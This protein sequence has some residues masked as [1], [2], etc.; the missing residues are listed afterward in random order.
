MAIHFLHARWARLLALFVSH[1]A[2]AHSYNLTA[3][4]CWIVN[5]KGFSMRKQTVNLWNGAE[6][7]AWATSKKQ[8]T[9]WSC[10]FVKM[11]INWSNGVAQ[12]QTISGICIEFSF[13]KFWFVL[14]FRLFLLG[15]RIWRRQFPSSECFRILCM[16]ERSPGPWGVKITLWTVKQNRT[17]PQTRTFTAT[18]PHLFWD[19]AVFVRFKPSTKA[20][21]AYN[22]L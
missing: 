8:N 14:L 6:W 4:M 12:E 9:I 7:W 13:L 16:K 19:K 5:I 1:K 2:C 15:C 11:I 17:E 22:L 21:Y 3:N 10:W 20:V 18:H